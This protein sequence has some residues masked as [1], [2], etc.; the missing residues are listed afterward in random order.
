MIHILI[1]ISDYVSFAGYIVCL[2]FTIKIAHYSRM[3]AFKYMAVGTG[4]LVL[5]SG[6]WLTSRL[7]ITSF[8]DALS[9][10]SKVSEAVSVAS[11]LIYIAG[12]LFLAVS[13]YRLY[14]D[15][16]QKNKV[17]EQVAASDR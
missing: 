15:Y 12:V 4:F 8:P 14:R 6:I 7:L 9:Y 2:I 1:T 5:N 17:V 11:L 3:S 13:L 16:K 10:W